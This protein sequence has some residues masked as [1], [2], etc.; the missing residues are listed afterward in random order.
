MSKLLT[1]T[2]LAFSF[3]ALLVAVCVV[4]VMGAVL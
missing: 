3:L 4:K 2:I 1:L